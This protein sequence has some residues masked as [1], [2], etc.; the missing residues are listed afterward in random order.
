MCEKSVGGWGHSPAITQPAM[1]QAGLLLSQHR[2]ED[3]APGRDGFWLSCVSMSAE[4]W[5]GWDG[6]ELYIYC[7]FFFFFKGWLPALVP[8]SVL[9][10]FCENATLRTTSLVPVSENW[11]EPAWRRPG[12]ALWVLTLRPGPPART[13]T[14]CMFKVPFLVPI[15]LSLWVATPLRSCLPVL[16][17]EECMPRA[18]EGGQM[19]RCI[20][21]APSSTRNGCWLCLMLLG[22][23]ALF[24][25][26]KRFTYIL[27][28]YTK[29][30][31]LVRFTH[32]TL[33]DL[34]LFHTTF[35]FFSFYISPLKVVFHNGTGYMC[36]VALCV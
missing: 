1:W 34:C 19:R 29:R 35:L 11:G 31:K 8:T 3:V 10:C 12:T 16:L 4:S 21:T 17:E 24:R 32:S 13:V 36:T 6:H 14:F 33:S 15:H 30:H 22:A 27:H 2:A 20:L 23:P 25:A 26:S 18:A 5:G 28:W 7:H 9:L